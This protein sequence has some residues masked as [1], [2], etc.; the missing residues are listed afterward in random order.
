MA[1]YT[2]YDTEG[3]IV[4]SN[5]ENDLI[6]LWGSLPAVKWLNLEQSEV[7]RLQ[8]NNLL[9]IALNNLFLFDK[10]EITHQIRNFTISELK[11]RA[12]AASS[13]PSSI[14]FR[15]AK[16][17]NRAKFI[18]R[19]HKQTIKAISENFST[20]ISIS[21]GVNAGVIALIIKEQNP[22]TVLPLDVVALALDRNPSGGVKIPR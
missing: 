6:A 15:I 21:L 2:F 19:I 16:E 12:I 5:F 13:R 22:E 20:G 14:A 17:G 10:L 18:F 7:S 4:F 1:T 3:S 11:K 8:N 9:E